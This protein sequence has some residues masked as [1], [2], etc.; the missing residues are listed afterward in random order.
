MRTEDEIRARL[1]LELMAA[2]S[3]E[4][5][6]S[7]AARAA[8]ERA[9]ILEWCLQTSESEFPDPGGNGSSKGEGE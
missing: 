7:H 5:S 2:T 6:E 3:F 8:E 9:K 1:A 4:S